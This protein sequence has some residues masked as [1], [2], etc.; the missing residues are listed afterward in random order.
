MELCT[1]DEAVARI[2][3]TDVV[4]GSLGPG[5]PSGVFEAL[6]RRDD[7][8]DLV[9][10]ASLLTNLYSVFGKPGVRLLS[11]FYGPV[12]RMLRAAGHPVEFI[13]G[14]FRRFSLFA[15]KMAPRVMATTACPPDADGMMSLSLHAGATISEL[16]RCG[17]DPDRLLIVEAN[18]KLP[19]T[20]GLPPAHPHA[21]HVDEVDLVVECARDPRVLPDIE[22]GPVEMAIAEYARTFVHDRSTLQT[23]I[24]AIPSAVAQLLA[25]GPGGDYGI[26]SEMFT[27]G[28]M[29]LH[30]AGKVTNQHKG[31]Y[32]GFSAVTFSM[33]TEELYEWLDGNEEVRFLP[34]ECINTPSVIQSNRNMLSINGALS[35]DLYGQIVADTIDG[36]QHSG[37]GGHED[38]VSGASLDREDRSLI[39]MPATASV[40]G[41]EVSR[42]VA[43]HPAGT[44]VTT[45]RHQLDVV[46]TEHGVAEV[47]GLTVGDRARALA[48]VAAPAFRD[49]LRA[50]A[51]KV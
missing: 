2:R 15:E 23:G 10:F 17:K 42:I 43:T 49:E 25:D 45:P 19:R 6:G 14:D 39:C 20:M 24:G 32:N 13:P 21:L 44:I 16:R 46:I 12:E 4:A 5:E 11:A 31:V 8:E 48:D 36:R 35:I 28:L 33:G 22:A 27:T 29:H 18:A 9:V 41:S 30:K 34:V 7:W 50:A 26:H 3:P 40:N 1:F 38:F 37:I 47:A 51:E